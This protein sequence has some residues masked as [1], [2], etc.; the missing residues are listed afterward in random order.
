MEES[1]DGTLLSAFEFRWNPAAKARLPKLFL[2]TYPDAESGV[3][4]PENAREWLVG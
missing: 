2:Q 1:A 4:T 3:I